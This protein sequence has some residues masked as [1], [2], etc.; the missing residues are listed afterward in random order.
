MSNKG[1][2]YIYVMYVYDC[3]AILKNPTKNRSEKYMILYFAELITDLKCRGINPGFHIKENKES[4]VLIKAMT[5]MD[6]K[7]Q[8]VP[9]INH[10]A[11][12]AEREIQT[13]K[14]HF[15][16]GLCSVD[17][18]FHLQLW[19]ILLHKATTSLNIPRQSRIHTHLLA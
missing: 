10:I 18:Y 2:I 17:S 7:Y 3:N 9:P 13:F 5:T 6:I 19:Y 8:L 1:N 4:T 11:N 15:I 14:N 16:A 12:N